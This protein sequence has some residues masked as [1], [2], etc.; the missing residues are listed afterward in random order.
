MPALRSNSI[1]FRA[2]A[3]ATLL[4]AMTC[5][6]QPPVKTDPG[7]AD[8][9]PNA[10]SLRHLEVDQRLPTGFEGVY[11]FSKV[12]AFGHGQNLFMR[13]DGAITAVFPRSVYV[14]AR[15]GMIPEVPPD[16]IFHIGVMPTSVP[17][18]PGRASNATVFLNRSFATPS[19]GSEA[20]QPVIREMPIARS[21]ISNEIY[22]RHRLATLLTPDS[23]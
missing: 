15:E 2:A 9:S 4:A 16:T 1:H 21:L 20:E 12:D 17:T 10:V 3:A 19:P 18:A 8:T 13:I 6:A 5:L 23:P 14:P 11:Q 22:R 7:Y